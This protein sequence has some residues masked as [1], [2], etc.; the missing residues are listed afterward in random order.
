MCMIWFFVQYFITWPEDK[1]WGS[2][3]I[4]SDNL[5][6]EISG[7]SVSS[8]IN[9][10]ELY[11][12]QM[13]WYDFLMDLIYLTDIIQEF[14]YFFIRYDC[15]GSGI[16]FGPG[17]CS[18]SRFTGFCSPS[19]YIFPPCISPYIHWIKCVFDSFSIRLV[20]YYKDGFHFDVFYNPWSYLRA[21]GIDF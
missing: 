6:G 20:K 16:H 15:D 11:P 3:L 19:C 7:H 1:I 9:M 5:S 4:R 13:P 8:G 21:P 14:F 12:T 10:I 2:Q 18:H 17:M